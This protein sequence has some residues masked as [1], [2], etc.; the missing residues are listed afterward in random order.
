MALLFAVTI[1]CSTSSFDR[2]CVFC[3]LSAQNSQLPLLSKVSETCHIG[4]IEHALGSETPHRARFQKFTDNGNIFRTFNWARFQKFTDKG[5]I[6]RIFNWAWFQFERLTD[7][8]TIFTWARFQKL[9]DRGTIRFFFT[10]RFQNQEVALTFREVG[11][12]HS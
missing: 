6:F 2:A 10:A 4:C 8:G 12:A 9:S 11:Q 1:T 5:N 7:K 3:W